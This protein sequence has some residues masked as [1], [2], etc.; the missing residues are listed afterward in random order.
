MISN[1]WVPRQKIWRIS[2][3]RG[4]AW[5]ADARGGGAA[6][7]FPTLSKMARRSDRDHCQPAVRAVPI[8]PGVCVFSEEVAQA[9]A[10][11]DE[12][13]DGGALA[14]GVAGNDIHIWV[15]GS[16]SWLR[17]PDVF[18]KRHGQRGGACRKSRNAGRKLARSAAVRIILKNCPRPVASWRNCARD[19][20]EQLWGARTGLRIMWFV[21]ED[22]ISTTSVLPWP[23]H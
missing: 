12:T 19:L 16:R 8:S 6:R 15:Q 9:I 21:D 2:C 10:H 1:N 3:Q 22:L 11:L 7:R 5:N 13:L 17:L 20:P 18:Y 14:A 23:G 4:L